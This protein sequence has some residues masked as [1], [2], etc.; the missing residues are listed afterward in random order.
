MIEQM[1]LIKCLLHSFVDYSGKGTKSFGVLTGEQELEVRTP[2][3][4][5]EIGQSH[6]AK[7]VSYIIKHHI[8][9]LYIILHY[10]TLRCNKFR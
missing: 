8:I 3:Y 7:S 1:R 4:G 5:P 2:T 9:L 6:H 10:D